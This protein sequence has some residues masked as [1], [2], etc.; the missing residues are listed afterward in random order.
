MSARAAE[1]LKQVR[2]VAGYTTYID[3]IRPLIT[4]KEI[5]STGMTKE[6]DRVNAAIAIALSGKSCAI[7]SSGDAGVYAMAGLAFEI[8]K[9]KKI[10]LAARGAAPASNEKVL[11]IEVVPG[12]PAL[13][14]GA[15][16]LG[17]PA[18]PRFCRHQPQ[19]PAHPLG[20]HRSPDR[21]RGPGRFRHRPL[22]SQE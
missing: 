19:R 17:A 4:D 5:V 9:E 21:C 6:V 10:R 18:D 3:L 14:S 12:I 2:T 13:C 7:V 11:E 22:Q 16:L 15:S 8:C 1:V 20:G